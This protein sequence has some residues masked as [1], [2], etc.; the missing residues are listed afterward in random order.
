MSLTCPA[1]NVAL[2][3]IPNRT[4]V[5]AVCPSC[6]GTWLDNASSRSVVTT[7]LEPHVK[8]RARE[9]DGAAAQRR[10][11]AAAGGYREAAVR[12]PD[13]RERLCAACRSPLRRTTF[14]AARI[15]LDVCAAHGTWFDAGELWAMAQHFEIEAMSVDED[16][17]AFGREIQAYREAEVFLDLRP[18]ALLTGFLRR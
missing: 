3:P 10:E 12:P 7:F 9:A 8:Q 16:V 1:C 4:G 14:E 5:A 13:A 17:A 2:C 15:E 6:G 11:A 18:A